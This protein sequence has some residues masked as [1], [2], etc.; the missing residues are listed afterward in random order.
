[1]KVIINA[2]DLGISSEVNA[3]TFEL[4]SQGR[5]TSATLMANGS[6]VEA[7]AR[8]TKDFRHCSFGVHLN[9]DEFR[10]LTTHPGLQPILDAD[11]RLVG[12][13]LRQVR[14]RAPLREAI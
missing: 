5:V 6:A 2:D 13:A 10:P 14:I 11:R 12:N 7:A 1:M 8:C 4:M 3:A 9:V